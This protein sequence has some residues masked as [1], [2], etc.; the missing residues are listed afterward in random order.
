MA[1]RKLEAVITLDDKFSRKAQNVGRNT[2]KLKSGFVSLGKA[3]LAAAGIVGTAVVA[4][5]GK[6]GKSAL[7]AAAD[8]ETMSTALQSAFRGDVAAAKEAMNFISEFSDRTPFLLEQVGS[9]FLQLKNLGI[10]PTERALTAFGDIAASFA[11]KTLKDFTEAVADATTGEFERLKEFGI[12]AKVQGENVELIYKGMSKTIGNSSDEIQEALIEIGETEYGGAMALQAK[13]LTGLI[14]TLQTKFNIAM[15]KMAQDSGL[16]DAAK[17]AVEIL[18]P[19][20]NRATE[21]LA[22]WFQDVGPK[23]SAYIET[24]KPDLLELWEIFK[25]GI[26]ELK[27]MNGGFD[28]DLIPSLIEFAKDAIPKVIG[29][30]KI[31]IPIIVQVIGVIGK[32]IS[33]AIKVSIAWE[34]MKFSVINAVAGLTASVT[35]KIVHIINVVKSIPGQIRSAFNGMVSAIKSAMNRAASHVEGKINSIKG[36]ISQATGG[37]VQFNRGGQIGSFGN[38]RKFAAGGVVPGT[39]NT[40]S[41]PAMLRPG[42]IVLN[43]DRGQTLGN[44]FNNTFNIS[45]VENPKQIAQMVTQELS[46]QI[47]L[48]DLGAF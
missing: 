6:L 24:I 46:R 41:V 30:L 44:T 13:T 47:E 37:F 12:K 3:G 14:S 40:D 39:G 16:L 33:F 20:I 15:V 4:G 28:E 1:E 34:K 9:A 29:A 17:K 31:A 32:M 25:I 43:P 26:R 48:T 22:R 45:G 42:E 8:Y 35:S 27:N 5:M 36:S 23:F 18:I 19:F 11:N 10:E 38:V 7:E 21:A 2:D